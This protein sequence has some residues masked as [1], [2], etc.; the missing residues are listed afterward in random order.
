VSKGDGFYPDD[1]K[2]T[3]EHEWLALQGNIGTVGITHFAQS[4]LG[5]I[6]YVE[7]P[8]VGTAMVAGEPFGTVESVKAVSELFA[9]ASGEV[10]EVNTALA[11]AQDAVN[12]DPYGEGWIIKM[13]VAEPGETAGLL[14]AAQYRKFVEDEAN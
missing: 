4:E 2:Y 9:P 6:V 1:L 7:L 14:T 11:A 13:R 8:A 3:K 5:D 12:R 10:V